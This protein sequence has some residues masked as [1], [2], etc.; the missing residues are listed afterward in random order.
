MLASGN[1]VVV[2]VVIKQK[3][4][5]FLRSDMGRVIVLAGGDLFVVCAA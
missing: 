2:F 1:M 4:S 5:S 3:M